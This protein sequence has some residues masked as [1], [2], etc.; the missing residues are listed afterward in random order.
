[1][2]KKLIITAGLAA[3]VASPAFAGQK[4]S[5]TA[6]E[7]DNLSNVDPYFYNGADASATTDSGIPHLPT[8]Y[9]HMSTNNTYRFFNIGENIATMIGDGKH[10]LW[11]TQDNGTV[12]EYLNTEKNADGS[13]LKKYYNKKGNL[14]TKTQTE[15]RRANWD[16]KVAAGKWTSV[17]VLSTPASATADISTAASVASYTHLDAPASWNGYRSNGWSPAH[18][19]EVVDQNT[20]I[21]D[22]GTPADASDDYRVW[23]DLP[24]SHAKYAGAYDTH[25]AID[26]PSYY[27]TMSGPEYK[28][29]RAAMNYAFAQPGSGHANVGPLGVRAGLDVSQNYTKI[30]P[31][32]TLGDGR[33][34]VNAGSVAGDRNADPLV[35]IVSDEIDYQAIV[36]DG[37][38]ANSQAVEYYLVERPFFN[39]EYLFIIAVFG[40]STGAHS[41]VRPDGAY[42]DHLVANG[43]LGAANTVLPTAAFITDEQVT[44]INAKATGLYGV[45][46]PATGA[47]PSVGGDFGASYYGGSWPTTYQEVTPLCDA[48]VV[49]IKFY[50]NLDGQDW[51][52]AAKNLANAT[53]AGKS[54]TGDLDGDA[55]ATTRGYTT[56]PGTYGDLSAENGADPYLLTNNPMTG[57]VE[58]FVNP[59]Q[60][61]TTATENK[62]FPTPLD[63]PVPSASLVFTPS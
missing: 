52:D 53:I 14:V 31:L 54:N 35:S 18:P 17:A 11:R 48:V 56:S 44:A 45:H 46:H 5:A 1:M 57:L 58:A 34:W 15:K 40:D 6:I 3:L 23:V 29:A 47:C 26:L 63:A 43:L 55:S 50:A 28:Y 39:E 19:G 10:G 8:Y 25:V 27:C 13:L 21:T 38:D 2:M 62:V 22:A 37:S 20:G 60:T 61:T 16:K 36:T 51:G 41:Y 42:Y 12:R 30:M 4:C 49:D 9:G 33:I 24:I 59:E 32:N 7:G